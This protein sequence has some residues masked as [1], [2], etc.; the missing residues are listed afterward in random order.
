MCFGFTCDNGWGRRIDE[1][2]EGHGQIPESSAGP[3]L[4]RARAEARPIP[5]QVVHASVVWRTERAPSLGRRRCLS[6]RRFLPAGT[7]ALSALSPAIPDQAPYPR[8]PPAKSNCSAKSHGWRHPPPS[9]AGSIR[10]ARSSGPR[11]AGPPHLCKT[12]PAISSDRTDW[13]MPTERIRENGGLACGVTGV[14]T[15]ESGAKSVMTNRPA[16][17]RRAIASSSPPPV[18]SA[19]Q[20]AGRGPRILSL[21]DAGRPLRNRAASILPRDPVVF[22]GTPWRSLGRKFHRGPWRR[23]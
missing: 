16:G 18:A 20:V 9:P 4:A 23:H 15:E 5:V 17:I 19:H 21:S 12:R 1:S 22:D 11:T 10:R 6:C 13:G 2:A 7:G 14:A 8:A 3:V